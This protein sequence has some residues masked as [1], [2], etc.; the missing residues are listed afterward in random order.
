MTSRFS[1][2]SVRLDHGRNNL[3]PVI[4]PFPDWRAFV[5]DD[6]DDDEVAAVVEEEEEEKEEKGSEQKSD[7]DDA[8]ATVDRKGP[9]QDPTTTTD[10]SSETAREGGRRDRR[11]KIFNAVDAFL[12]DRGRILWVLDTGIAGADACHGNRSP[13]EKRSSDGADEDPPP[14]FLAIDVQTNQ[15]S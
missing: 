11:R 8:V 7:G 3:Y 12:D 4:R 9:E 13:V 1:L 14:K 5:D 15:V 2:G 10:H 6:D